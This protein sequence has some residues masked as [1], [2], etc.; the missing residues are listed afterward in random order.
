MAP[1]SNSHRAI[2]Q[3][4][5]LHFPVRIR[6]ARDQLGRERKYD[7]MHRWLDHHIGPGRYWFV[8][9]RGDGPLPETIRF[10][11]VAVADAQ[12]F[13]DAPRRR[14]GGSPFRSFRYPSNLRRL[15]RCLQM[16]APR[17]SSSTHARCP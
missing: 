5:E 13:I 6:I 8:G 9:Q 7:M 4:A 1:R 12:A 3:D 10:Y 11:F 14:M 2:S 17:N 16:R 15:D